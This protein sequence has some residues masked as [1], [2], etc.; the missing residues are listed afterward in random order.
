MINWL[1]GKYNEGKQ[2]LIID[3][4]LTYFTDVRP[5]QTVILEYG[6]K[7]GVESGNSP[8]K[9]K[10]NVSFASLLSLFSA[11]LLAICDREITCRIL[12]TVRSPRPRISHW[13]YI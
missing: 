7:R 1:V 5:G 13:R 12:R 2:G 3:V 10:K 8:E 9:I 6:Q 11:N 4:K